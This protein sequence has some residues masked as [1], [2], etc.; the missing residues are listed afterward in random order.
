MKHL[1]TIGDGGLCNQLRAIASAKRLC[2][3]YNAR[4]SILW[5]WEQLKELFEPDPNVHIITELPTEQGNYTFY[6]TYIQSQMGS[7]LTQEFDF[8]DQ[9]NVII[10]ACQIFND[11][12][13]PKITLKDLIDYLPKPSTSVLATVADFSK[14]HF[15]GKRVVGVHIRRTDNINSIQMSPDHLF[16]SKIEKLIQAGYKIFLATDNQ[17]TQSEYLNRFPGNIITYEKEGSLTVRWPKQQFNFEETREDLVDLLLLSRCEYVVG[18][19]WSSYSRTA[20]VLNGSPECEVLVE[21]N[22]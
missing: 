2:S 7:H 8:R 4:C 11:R 9:C 12:R 1:I 22:S 14:K 15:E 16:I 19:H 17:Q 20:M 18:C 5:P 21:G 3:L 13:E 6:N 10:E